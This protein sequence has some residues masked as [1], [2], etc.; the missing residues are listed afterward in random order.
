MVTRGMWAWYGAR[1]GLKELVGHGV[2]PGLQVCGSL[3]TIGT[4]LC[5]HDQAQLQG[6]CR[7]F[8]TRT[9]GACYLLGHV[10][11]VSLSAPIM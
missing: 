10:A 2:G 11:T 9:P 4:M 3:P 6:L 5:D 7:V 1:N 8:H